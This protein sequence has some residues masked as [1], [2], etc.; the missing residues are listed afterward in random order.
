MLKQY[1]NFCYD[2]VGNYALE[3]LDYFQELN[4]QLSR[5]NI[6]ISLPEYVSMMLLSS[7]LTF[8]ISLPLLVTVLGIT[9]GF[10][11]AI[12][13]LIV[14]IIVSLATMGGFYFYPS[15]LI[16][17]RASKIRDTLPFA[18][19]YMSTLAGTGTSLE[20]LFANL[21]QTEE[22]GEISKEAKKIHRDLDTFGLDAN[23]ALQRAAERTP[24]EDFRELLWGINHSL[25]SGGS[26]RSF[27]NERSN[28]LMKDYQRRV[29]EF[30]EQLSLLVEMYITV[31]I[32]GSIVFTSMSVVMTSFTPYAPETIVLI[33]MTA[34]FIGLPIISALFILVVD[35]M[36]PGGVR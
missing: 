17:D 33:Q 14:S 13:G 26:L 27:L 12:F 1:A 6:E 22:Y 30:S 28:T 19:M 4:P 24:S 10:S 29:E 20:E 34:I 23:E 9:S 5:A 21:A 11:G 7:A 25:S 31:V 2:Q 32:V 8:M 18:S 15:I 35:S 36:A 3:Y 16:Q